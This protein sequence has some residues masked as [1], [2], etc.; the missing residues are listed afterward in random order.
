MASNRATYTYVLVSIIAILTLSGF[1]YNCK[2]E[3]YIPYEQEPYEH[4]P[5]EHEPYEEDTD[6]E[7]E[8][9]RDFNPNEKCLCNG[10]GQKMCANKEALQYSYLEGNTE[11]KDFSKLQEPIWKS[12]DFNNY[13]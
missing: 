8:Y 6:W 4:E 9:H 7:E 10:V 13:I 12:T 2:N 1:L 3:S 11:Y 5:Y